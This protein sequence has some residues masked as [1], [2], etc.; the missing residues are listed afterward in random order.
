MALFALGMPRFSARLVAIEDWG[1]LR[2][3]AGGVWEEAAGAVGKFPVEDLGAG[4]AE[5]SA[6]CLVEAAV[7]FCL[8]GASLIRPASLR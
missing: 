3:D 8:G 7:F 6:G 1:S 2:R 4:E 5:G